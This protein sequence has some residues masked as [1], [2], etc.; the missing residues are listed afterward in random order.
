MRLRGD[1]ER[2]T[3]ELDVEPASLVL[4]F[5]I[6]L[7]SL[8]RMFLSNYIILGCLLVVFSIH[9]RR[10]YPVRMQTLAAFPQGPISQFRR[11]FVEE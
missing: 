10:A 2:C 3:G 8:E 9:D 5:P 7:P 11:V 4:T 1:A 6:T